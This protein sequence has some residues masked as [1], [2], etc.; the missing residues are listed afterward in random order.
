MNKPFLDSYEGQSTVELIALKDTYRIDSLV[1]AFEQAIQAKAESGLS[2]TERFVLAI[3]AMER[4]VNNGGWDQFFFNTNNQYDAILVVALEAIGCLE[5]AEIAREALDVHGRGGEIDD[6]EDLDSRYYA[7]T[8]SIEDKLF[9]YIFD[10]QGEIELPG[11]I[12]KFSEAEET[13][14]DVGGI[15]GKK[16]WWR[17]W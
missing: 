8:E 9:H 7:M 6:F 2:Q 13:D 10:H 15:I 1:L 5:T 16:P 12:G 4:E 14:F 3:E 11:N 17:F